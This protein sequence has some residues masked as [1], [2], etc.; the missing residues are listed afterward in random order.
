MRSWRELRAAGS[1]LTTACSGRAPR[2]AELQSRQATFAVTTVTMLKHP[3]AFLPLIMSLAALVVVL[4]YL[5]IYG[6]A[7]QVDE[8]AAAHLWQLLMAGQ[9]PV[10][11]FFALKWLPRSP[12]QAVWM[13][14][15]QVGAALAAALPVFRLSW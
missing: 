7:P 11:L 3:S 12:R 6:P 4:A 15:I 14:L 1:C 13:I 8:G 5:A 2:A 10:V 9:A